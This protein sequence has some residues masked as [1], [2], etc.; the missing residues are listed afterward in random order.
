M[1]TILVVDDDKELQNTLQVILQSEGYIVLTADTGKKALQIIK[2]NAPNIVLLDIRLPDINGIKILEKVKKDIPDYECCIIILTAY[3]DIKGAI[4]SMKLGAFDYITKPFDNDELLLTIQKAIRSQQLKKEVQVLREKLEEKI[5]YEKEMGTSFLIKDV[6]KK[7]S[8]IAPTN[9]SVIVQGKTGTGKEVIAHLIHKKSNRR[10]E[11]FIPIDCGA[12]PESLIESELFGYEKGAFTGAETAKMGKF[13]QADKGTLFLDEIT[14]LPEPAQAKLLRAIEEKQVYH[15]G[16]KQSIR[17][18]VRI[19]TAS[20]VD[21]NDAVHNGDFREDLYHR[22]NEFKIVLPLLKERKEDIPILA[23]I[24][25]NEAKKEFDKGIDDFSSE[26]MKKLLKYHWPGNV[27]ELKNIIKKAVLVED[28]DHITPES[29]EFEEEPVTE[30]S[31]QHSIERFTKNIIDRKQT[32][33]EITSKLNTDIEREIILSVLREVHFNK[34]IAAKILE[35]DRNTL[36]K[37]LKEL[38]IKA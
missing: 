15:L 24:F 3:G 19:L 8:M 6:L 11:E 30:P 27:R 20:N 36:Y 38:D 33:K 1:S 21:L 23:E 5:T 32:L 7:V 13:E 10:C 4:K 28:G 29:L 17:V 18:D 31:K 14:N 37:K 9:M 25:L 22:L 2:S 34:T 26:A 16:G 35:I 12:I